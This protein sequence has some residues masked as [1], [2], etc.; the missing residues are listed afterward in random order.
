MN[1]RRI[2]WFLA[3]GAAAASPALAW[4]AHGHRTITL[5]AMDGFAAQTSGLPDWLTNS[6]ARARVAYQ[7]SEPDRYRST[8]MVYMSHENSPEHYIDI[9][10]LEQFGLT[11][12][13]VPPLRYQYVAV[14][15]VARHEHPENVKPHNPKLDPSGE[16]EWP[17]FVPHAIMEHYVKLSS[18]FRTVRTLE[19]INDPKR[20]QELEMAKANAFAEMG[21]LSHFVGDAAQPL[22]T[23]AHHHG[24]V[25]DN[26][27]GYTTDRGFHAYID[28]TILSIHHLDHDSLK[29]ECK[30][31]AKVDQGDPWNDV[32]A[33]I[34]R[35]H[36][37][38]EPLYLLKKTGELEKD[39]GKKFMSER[40]T[41]AAGMLAAMY[42]AAWASGTPNDKDKPDFVKYDVPDP[43]VK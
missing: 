42:Q 34:Q 14:M 17:G 15:A 32:I 4:D 2:A 39:E 22:H 18:A 8:K 31:D 20:A 26:P 36:D 23:T 27:K 7:A 37:M 41:D 24:W 11:L 25:G 38:V 35:S 21:F 1:M 29:D 19:Q 16:Q 12:S 43:R 3:A 13:T 28:G 33:Y 30:F 9:E 40:L 6:D 10:D 5:L